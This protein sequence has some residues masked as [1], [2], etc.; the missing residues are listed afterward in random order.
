[1]PRVGTK[2]FSYSKKGKAAAKKYAKRTGK[3]MTKGK[4]KKG[5][6]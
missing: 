3:R 1:M 4:G 2:K 6:Y 5:K